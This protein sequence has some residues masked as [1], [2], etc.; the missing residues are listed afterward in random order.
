M[1]GVGAPRSTGVFKTL[2]DLRNAVN[3][4]HETGLKTADIA[5]KTGVSPSTV[6]RILAGGFSSKHAKD[7]HI[8]EL[9][10][11]LDSLWPVPPS[12]LEKHNATAQN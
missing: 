8:S 12:I 11:Q 2:Q 4:L 1:S 3:T 5:N 7:A 6:C 9:R 10:R